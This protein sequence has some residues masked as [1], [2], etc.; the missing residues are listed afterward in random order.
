MSHSSLF[1]W[2]TEFVLQN[3]ICRIANSYIP[4]LHNTVK[5]SDQMLIVCRHGDVTDS[6]RYI[7][8]KF[9]GR[10]QFL[11]YAHLYREEAEK[12]LPLEYNFLAEVTQNSVRD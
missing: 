4:D 5:L 9:G 2:L 12:H 7:K 1:E 6:Y 11:A 8:L 10:R 3:D